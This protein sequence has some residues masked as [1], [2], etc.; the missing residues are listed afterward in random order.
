MKLLYYIIVID[1]LRFI[2]QS[3]LIPWK[4]NHDHHLTLFFRVNILLVS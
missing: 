4:N 1:K 2:P 3:I